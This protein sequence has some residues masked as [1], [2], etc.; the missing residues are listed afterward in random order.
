MSTASED[1]IRAAAAAIANARGAR[2]GAPA[3]ANILDVLDELMGGKLYREVMEDAA[4]AL[5][6]AELVRESV[7]FTTL[8]GSHRCTVNGPQYVVIEKLDP[9]TK[10]VQRVETRGPNESNRE[11]NRNHAK[12]T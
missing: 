12:E 11:S 1:E 2:R 10:R 5:A 6:A 8:D 3:V 9:R 4:A 7:V